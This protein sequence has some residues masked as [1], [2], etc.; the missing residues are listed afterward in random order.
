ML[1]VSGPA[2]K[3]LPALG[4]SGSRFFEKVPELGGVIVAVGNDAHVHPVRATS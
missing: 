2:V 1:P 4:V 3:P